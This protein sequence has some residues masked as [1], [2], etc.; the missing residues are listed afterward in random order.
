MVAP[1]WREIDISRGTDI[2]RTRDT[3]V[4]LLESGMR[5]SEEHVEERKEWASTWRIRPIEE[6]WQSRPVISKVAS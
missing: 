5:E 2:D 4:R 1:T 6:G 3:V